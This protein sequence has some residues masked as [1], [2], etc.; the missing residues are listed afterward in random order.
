[1]E[2]GI[3]DFSYPPISNDSLHEVNNGNVVVVVNFAILKDFTVK[4]VFP[5][6]KICNCDWSFSDGKIVKLNMYWQLNSIRIHGGC[7]YWPYLVLGSS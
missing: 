4:L 1:M 5:H 2:R 7:Q 3:K 6:I